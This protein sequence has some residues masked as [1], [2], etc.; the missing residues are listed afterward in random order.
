MSTVLP[1]C[2]SCRRLR[3]L[4]LA[5]GADRTRGNW[6]E[7][8]GGRVLHLVPVSEGLAP[9]GVTHRASEWWLQYPEE[10]TA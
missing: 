9:C 6:A 5:R 1:E 4:A 2:K 3:R 10:V 7:A 8:E